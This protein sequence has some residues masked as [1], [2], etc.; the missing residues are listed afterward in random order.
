[1]NW[2]DCKLVEVI[3]DKVSGAP[4]FKGTRLPA[5]TVIENVDAYLDEGLSLDQA[6]EA[7]LESFPTVPHGMEGIRAVLSYRAEREHQS[8]L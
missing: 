6:I 5:S 8:A 1:M 2:S 4:L 3:P 7:T